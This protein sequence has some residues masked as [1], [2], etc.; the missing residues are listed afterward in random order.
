LSHVAV[1]SPPLQEKEKKVTK[2]LQ[3]T[4]S[5]VLQGLNKKTCFQK[6]K[7]FEKASP[8]KA[9]TDSFMGCAQAKKITHK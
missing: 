6:K 9:S 1:S 7:K 8:E 5:I 4:I 3:P 2:C